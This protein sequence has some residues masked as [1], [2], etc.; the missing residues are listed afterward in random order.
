M[1]ALLIAIA[2]ISE[3]PFNPRRRYDATADAELDALDA[4]LAEKVMGWRWHPVDECWETTAG[5]FER[6]SWE[7]TRSASD[8][9]EVVEK[10]LRE[11]AS[12]PGYGRSLLSGPNFERWGCKAWR[13]SQRRSIDGAFETG[14]ADTLRLATLLAIARA[15]GFVPHLSTDEK[16]DEKPK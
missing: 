15:C 3:S 16:R 10:W 4:F 1:Q 11:N 6:G 2:E 9:E 8:A 13:E 12:T 14:I 5:A 7:P